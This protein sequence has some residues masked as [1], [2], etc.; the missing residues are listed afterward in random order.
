MIQIL[1]ISQTLK[2]LDLLL[3]QSLQD[4]VVF[5]TQKTVK[6]GKH[7]WDQGIVSLEAFFEI[8]IKSWF[9]PKK[10]QKQLQAF[11]AACT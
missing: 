5:Y 7:S 6:R 4:I 11:E 9:G 2:A 8:T 3:K 10:G 1:I